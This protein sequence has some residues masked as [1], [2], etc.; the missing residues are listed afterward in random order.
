MADPDVW[1]WGS[2]HKA[3]HT[4]LQPLPTWLGS[5]GLKL[6]HRMSENCEAFDVQT[7]RC[8]FL[9]R[10]PGGVGYWAIGE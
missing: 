9:V 6:V 8:L 5:S 4:R 1:V 2:A 10:I 3:K 7:N